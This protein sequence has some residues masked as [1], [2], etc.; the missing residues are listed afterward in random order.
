MKTFYIKDINTIIS[1][2]PCEILQ[3]YDKIL[4]GLPVVHLAITSISLIIA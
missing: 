1:L 3:R 4:N 2:L